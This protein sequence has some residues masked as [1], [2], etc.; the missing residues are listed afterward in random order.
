MNGTVLIGETWWR[1][2]R[3]WNW[4]R[5]MVFAYS[6]IGAGRQLGLDTLIRFG[7]VKIHRSIRYRFLIQHMGI[8]VVRDGEM[9]RWRSL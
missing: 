7:L 1:G 8:F 2:G 3:G 6:I 5:R 9:E 4:V